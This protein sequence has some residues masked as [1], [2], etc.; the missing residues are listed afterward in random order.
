MI[1]IGSFPE[2]HV[3]LLPQIAGVIAASMSIKSSNNLKRVLEV[4]LAFGNYMNSSKRGAVY[5]FKLQSL[6]ALADT[7]S[8]D[9]KWTLL[10]YI[11]N[12]LDSYYP[13]AKCFYNELRYV[14]RACKASF[15]NILSDVNQIKRGMQM[16]EKQFEV[17]GDEI[18]K[19]FIS[20]NRSKVDK[21]I[22]DTETAKE[23]YENVVKYFGET[24]KTMPPETFFPMVSRFIEAYK[25][26]EKEVEER[27]IVE[28]KRV[29]MQRLKDEQDEKMR[30]KAV[31]DI[32]EDG[33][34]LV[35][36][37]RLNKRKDR[38]AIESKDGAIED[39]INYIKSE[40]YRRSD[41]NHRSIRRIPR[42][43]PTT[44]NQLSS[45]QMSTML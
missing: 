18:L 10:H 13:D 15:E 19:K 45:S 38:R 34:R 14:D 29:E 17:S 21:I 20:T 7:K 26:A 36:E 40:P 3:T 1:F 8:A 23:A 31:E 11:V 35:N 28:A 33:E 24:P 32:R 2:T 4:V 37:I 39:N 44:R 22:Q 27:K 9:K 12:V 43:E 30:R 42:S 6:D 16:T 5:G 25:K 41:T